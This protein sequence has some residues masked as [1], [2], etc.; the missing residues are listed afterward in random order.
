MRHEWKLVRRVFTPPLSLSHLCPTFASWLAG[1]AAD[2]WVL[3]WSSRT[4]W[5]WGLCVQ[6]LGG[7]FDYGCVCVCCMIHTILSTGYAAAQDALKSEG[8]CPLHLLHSG[9]HPLQCNTRT[10]RHR[11]RN[12]SVRPSS[13]VL[14]STS[15]LCVCVCASDALG[16]FTPQHT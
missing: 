8:K 9:W 15:K 10:R 4:P 16:C 12:L 3:L 14:L 6:R 2:R 1:R 5:P 13:F 7:A 11:L